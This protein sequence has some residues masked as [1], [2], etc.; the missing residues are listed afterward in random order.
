MN[1][2]ENNGACKSYS[3]SCTK[4]VR[5]NKE[6]LLFDVV[7]LIHCLEYLN[8][9]II[10]ILEYSFIKNPIQLLIELQL[11]YSAT[12]PLL[13]CD[14]TKPYIALQNRVTH[15][16]HYVGPFGLCALY[17]NQAL[18]TKFTLVVCNTLKAFARR[19]NKN[20]R[21]SG[22]DIPNALECTTDVCV[23]TSHNAGF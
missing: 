3:L 17:T 18:P 23:S 1:S 16:I 5:R 7:V 14:L 20:N 8:C 21:F 9:I 10:I 13:L 11:Y 19:N 2:S 4:T 6:K 22:H 15:N 12:T